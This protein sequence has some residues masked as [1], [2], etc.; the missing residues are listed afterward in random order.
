MADD[1]DTSKWEIVPS[2]SGGGASAFDPAKWEVVKGP[3]STLPPVPSPGAVAEQAGNAV[4]NFLKPPD[5]RTHPVEFGLYGLQNAMPFLGAIPGL[6]GLAAEGLPGMLIRLGATTAVG[7]AAAGLSGRPMGSAAVE[8][9]LV[10]AGGEAVPALG[11]KLSGLSAAEKAATSMAGEQIAD[12]TAQKAVENQLGMTAQ[13]AQ[14]LAKGGGAAQL[15]GGKRAYREGAEA[16]VREVGDKY[17]PIYGPLENQPVAADELLKVGSGSKAAK[18]WLVGKGVTPS[19]SVGKALSKME[20]HAPPDPHTKQ[21]NVLTGVGA[22]G[23]ALQLTAEQFA[24][25]QKGHSPLPPP[26]IGQLRG[27]HQELMEEIGRPGITDIE[28]RALRDADK[29]ILET[30][31]NVIPDEQRPLLD[32]INAE[33]AQVKSLFP[34]KDFTAIRK[35][36]TLPQL[37][38]IVFGK[39]NEA[40]TSAA[41]SHM[42]EPQKKMMRDAFAAWILGEGGKPTEIL[43]KLAA[44]KDTVTVLYPK[45][46]FGNINTW[47]EMMLAQKKWAGGPPSLPSQKEFT[48]GVTEQ[49]KKLGLSP[50]AL[51]AATEALK[52]N[53]R[54]GRYEHYLTN[55]W[56]ISGAIM[57]YGLYGRD[58]AVTVPIAL[59]YLVSTAGFRAFANNPANLEMYRDFIMSP[60]TRKSGEAAGRLLVAAIN[61]AHVGAGQPEKQ[62]RAPMSD[63]SEGTDA[64]DKSRAEAMAPTPSASKRAEK[65]HKELD[66]KKKPQDVH[67]D[68]NR[69]RLTS[70]EVDNS[71]KYASTKDSSKVVSQPIPLSEVI[72]ALEQATPQELEMLLPLVQKRLQQELPQEKNMTRVA[73]ISRR[74]QAVQQKAQMPQQQEKA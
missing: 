10:G 50:E 6:G 11:R 57:G 38:G 8:S 46:S 5:P 14:G 44:N 73:N 47:R 12:I 13:Q 53:A 33:Y 23:G 20:A 31:R 61:D 60:W 51:Q 54:G 7:T 68:L 1:F 43:S 64:L 22:K 40:A 71:I 67:Q 26:T 34:R 59:G 29:P 66:K 15:A 39:G 45:S 74:F 32:Q 21:V 69:G 4:V 55:P 65:L 42:N 58:P 9:A 70:T 35:A 24:A 37:G 18:Q 19:P 49:I 30:L 25:L 28:R 27:H 41:L 3:A 2:P 16:A 62:L 48:A 63:M 36:G 72:D 56:I 52:P 17:E